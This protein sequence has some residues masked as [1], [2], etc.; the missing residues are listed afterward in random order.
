MQ[1]D[2]NKKKTL[3]IS[4]SFTKKLDPSS[5]GRNT[6][7]SYVVDNAIS[8]DGIDLIRE[9]LRELSLEKY[10]NDIFTINSLTIKG[11]YLPEN[12]KI[13]CSFDFKNPFLGMCLKI[14]G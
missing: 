13:Q 12:N 5:Y 9:P 6:K 11:N 2:K 14:L 1:K 3:T 4:S 8:K 7:K 10:N